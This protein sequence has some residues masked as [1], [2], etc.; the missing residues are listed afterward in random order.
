MS[1]NLHGTPWQILAETIKRR[2]E[3][4]GF[5]FGVSD[6]PIDAVNALADR[7]LDLEAERKEL[8]IHKPGK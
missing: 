6:Y 3:E 2:A 8:W 4:C 7:L 5:T 1:D